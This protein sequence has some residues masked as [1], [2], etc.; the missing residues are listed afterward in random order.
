MINKTF[1]RKLCGIFFSE[2]WKRVKMLK[3]RRRLMASRKRFQ[4]VA[5]HE[6]R[7]CF[8]A[9]LLSWTLLRFGVSESFVGKVWIFTNFLLLGKWPRSSPVVRTA[10]FP[11][12]SSFACP[13]AGLQL[14]IVKLNI[15]ST[16]TFLDAIKSTKFKRKSEQTPYRKILI[17]AV[18]GKEYCTNVR[19][20]RG[21]KVFSFHFYKPFSLCL[22]YT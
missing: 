1:K 15:V 5:A 8:V 20:V 6:L 12:F 18:F 11:C 21:R 4:T 14:S 19:T 22:F 17:E 7:L 3:V 2:P 9:S 10:L 16:A 13:I